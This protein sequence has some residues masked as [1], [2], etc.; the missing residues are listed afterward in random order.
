MALNTNSHPSSLQI[1]DLRFAVVGYDN[2]RWP[3]LKIDTNQGISGYG[4]VRDGASVRYALILKS[5]LLGENP[6][7]TEKLFR[8]IMQF[9]GHAR[10]GGG[11]CGVEMALMDLAGKA[12]GVPTYQLAGGQY[13]N[14]VKVYADTPSLKD[15]KEMGKRLCNRVEQGFKFLKMDLGIDL[16]EGLEG[17]L[18]QDTDI[19]LNP[20]IM[21]PFTA[22]QITE[23]GIEYLVEYAKI[24]RDQVG[25]SVPI[26]LDHFGHMGVESCIRLGQALDP[27]NFAWYEDM[28]PWQFPQQLRLLKESVTTPICT[29]EDIYL[30]EDFKKLLDAECV[31]YIHPD[32]AT[33]G[34]IME[35]KRIGDIA[36]EY[37][38]P[39]FLHQ[40]GSPVVAM[41]NVH[42]AAATEGF[43]AL[44]MHS[45]DLSWWQDLVK[46]PVK[47]I[48][49]QG[50]INVPDT[51]GLGIELNELIIKEHLNGPESLNG[52]FENTDE[53]NILDSN[54]RLWS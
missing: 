2:W 34:G 30:K 31:S 32:L 49:D 24:V 9:G 54:D 27:L 29:G 45:V 19:S 22:T 15:P 47:P 38:V 50:Y 12:W 8:K 5:R 21:H 51:P 20:N 4:E 1:T 25:Y 40:A 42:C 18:I 39:M 23:K 53:W 48:L 41:A 35:T 28:I 36:Q 13:R 52:F 33:S 3:I 14:R 17:T 16:L 10:L 46:K 6:C 44:E 11:V 37:G 7:H 26:A 43:V